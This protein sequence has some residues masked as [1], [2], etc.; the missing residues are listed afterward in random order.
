MFCPSCGAKNSTEQKFCRSCGMNLEQT[1]LS[2]LEQFPSA[3]RANL[4]RQERMLERLGQIAFG[5][6]GV[7]ILTAVGAIIYMIITKMI[8]TGINF[9]SGIL[10]VAFIFF[11]ALSLAYVIFNESLG[12][13]KKI[14]KS[15]IMP[16]IDIP[17]NT[18]RLLNESSIQSAQSI[19]ENTTELLPLENRTRKF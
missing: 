8:L 16:E 2:L 12:E 1:T 3:Q 17:K 15:N 5:G 11:A 14:M 18:E 6:F 13:K 19:T 9:W 4:Q 10:L 7:V